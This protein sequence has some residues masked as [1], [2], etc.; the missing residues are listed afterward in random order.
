M[1]GPNDMLGVAE[2]GHDKSHQGYP[3]RLLITAL[4]LWICVVIVTCLP[5]L[6][7]LA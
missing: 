1:P 5:V 4:C 6:L 7:H 3:P 2:R